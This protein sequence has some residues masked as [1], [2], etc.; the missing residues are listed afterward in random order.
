MSSVVSRPDQKL[1][2]AHFQVQRVPTR[3]RLLQKCARGIAKLV[4]VAADSP[5]GVMLAQSRHNRG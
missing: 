2:R 4:K 3:E 1:Y 5:R